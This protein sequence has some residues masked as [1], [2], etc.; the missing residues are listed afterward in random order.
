ML[1][2]C[3]CVW[4]IDFPITYF[5][6]AHTPS[7]L[8]S[9][10]SFISAVFKPSFWMYFVLLSFIWL[11]TAIWRNKITTPFL[12][13]LGGCILSFIVMYIVAEILKVIIGRARPFLLINDKISGFF[14]FVNQ[15]DYFS[16]PSGHILFITA[17]FLTICALTPNFLIRLLGL[18]FLVSIFVARIV[19]L[20]HF[21]GDCLFS[22]GIML[23][24]FQYRQCYFAKVNQAVQWLHEKTDQMH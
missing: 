24:I 2:F 9:Y 19:L 16:N 17:L 10:A 13:T 3:L 11:L 1:I 4:F 12:E 21:L 5:A 14:P 18:F 23:I 6:H 22:M 15:Y 7:W 8:K 20:K